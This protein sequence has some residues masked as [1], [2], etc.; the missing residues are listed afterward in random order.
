M[1]DRIDE[2]PPAGQ[3]EKVDLNMILFSYRSKVA[4][5]IMFQN[6][7]QNRFKRGSRV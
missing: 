5:Q 3:P 6:D 7:F 2:G 4:K 1:R